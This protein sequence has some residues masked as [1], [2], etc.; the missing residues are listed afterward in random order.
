MHWQTNE[1]LVAQHDAH[2]APSLYGM[3]SGTNRH[4]FFGLADLSKGDL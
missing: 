1:L 3:A 4:H 2:V